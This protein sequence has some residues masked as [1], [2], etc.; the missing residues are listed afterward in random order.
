M[1]SRSPFFIVDLIRSDYRFKNPEKSITSRSRSTIFLKKVFFF[2]KK[3]EE[4]DPW[5]AFGSKKFPFPNR[6]RSKKI[7]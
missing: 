3:M 2:K 7:C 1:L 6:K 5:A 4:R